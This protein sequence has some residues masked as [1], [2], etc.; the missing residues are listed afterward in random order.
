MCIRDRIVQ[1]LKPDFSSRSL[2]SIFLKKGLAHAFFGKHLWL[3]PVDGRKSEEVTIDEVL[4]EFFQQHGKPEIETIENL[5]IND[6]WYPVGIVLMRDAIRFSLIKKF[7]DDDSILLTPKR[8]V[9]EKKFIKAYQTAGALAGI[10]LDRI[11]RVNGDNICICPILTYE[12]FDGSYQRVEDPGMRSRC[13]SR[14]SRVTSKEYERRMIE[15]LNKILPLTVYL[16][17]KRLFFDQWQYTMLRKG[18]VTLE[19]WL[20][21]KKS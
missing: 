6:V 12:C 14:V 5:T 13:I 11:F 20:W 21:S 19:K 7:K 4:K 17:N 9:Y 18:E 1:Q 15:I 16:S 8:E 3:C 10:S 2:H